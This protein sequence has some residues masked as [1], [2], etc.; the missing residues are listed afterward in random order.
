[1]DIGVAGR[2]RNP[3]GTL[4]VADQVEVPGSNYA[5]VLSGLGDLQRAATLADA[6]TIIDGLAAS[7]DHLP[8]LLSDLNE[9]LVSIRDFIDLDKDVRAHPDNVR[10]REIATGSHASAVEIDL[11][12]NGNVESAIAT[13]ELFNLTLPETGT[14]TLKLTM[15]EA[16]Q[17]GTAANLEAVTLL[18]PDPNNPQADF[19]VPLTGFALDADAEQT[20]IIETQHTW[21]GQVPIRAEFR[22]TKLGDAS[23]VDRWR[24]TGISWT[25]TRKGSL[26]DALYAQISG[27]VSAVVA[28]LP[29]GSGGVGLGFASA[30]ELALVRRKLAALIYASVPDDQYLDY[31][32]YSGPA[33]A[34][35]IGSVVTGDSGATVAVPANALYIGIDVGQNDHGDV[36]R[37]ISEGRVLLDGT[38]TFDTAL[39]LPGSVWLSRIPADAPGTTWAAG[40]HYV[41]TLEELDVLRRL[42]S[43]ERLVSGVN[44]TLEALADELRELD[45]IRRHVEI[46]TSTVTDYTYGDDSYVLDGTAAELGGASRDMG[47]ITGFPVVAGSWRRNSGITA[48]RPLVSRGNG[49]AARQ[50]VRF[51]GDKVQANVRL[52]ATAATTDDRPVYPATATGVSGAGLYETIETLTFINGVPVPESDEIFY[53][54]NLPT[55]AHRVT[56]RW[57]PVLNNRVYPT[58]TFQL[59]GVGGSAQVS[60]SVVYTE[61]NGARWQIEMLWR[62]SE[63][64]LRVAASR[65]SSGTG[66]DTMNRIEVQAIWTYSEP[67]AAQPERDSWQDIGKLTADGRM[68]FILAFYE[69]SP[70]DY[71]V[72]HLINGEIGEFT[73]NDLTF[74]DSAEAVALEQDLYTDGS[75]GGF[76][77]HVADNRIRVPRRLTLRRRRPPSWAAATSM[78]GGSACGS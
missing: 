34:D 57:R 46:D 58:Q 56:L 5:A 11:A 72:R 67:I 6:L 19:R 42:D 20:F 24:A 35:A 13:D 40:P 30:S 48:P 51:D 77:Q 41:S 28:G 44:A 4:T 52:A 74:P 27:Y 7:G 18:L 45:D 63:R 70:G 69:P 68:D 36:S 10:T 78:T 38:A 64:D 33:A 2:L 3:F 21:E 71:R 25:L 1:M 15:Q 8:A 31:Q 9:H 47:A 60:N 43:L 39:T 75:V 55:T 65:L 22:Y 29:T 37:A 62:P 23:Q 32:F 76:L 54:R 14:L 66:F 59:D 16:A 61:P 26:V 12:G 53:A 50:L 49:A 17:S 73:F